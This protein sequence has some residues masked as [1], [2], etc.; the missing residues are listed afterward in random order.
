[1]CRS[2]LLNPCTTNGIRQHHSHT[3]FLHLALSCSICDQRYQNDDLLSA[4]YHHN[5][6]QLVCTTGI[7]FAACAA[8]PLK[9]CD[10]ATC[11]TPPWASLAHVSR[12]ATETQSHTTTAWIAQRLADSKSYKPKAKWGIR[13]ALRTIPKRRAAVFLQLASGHA[14]IGTHLA[15]I[16]K[17]EADTCWWCDSGR[18]QTRGH[19]FGGC[20]AWK[21]EV[22]TLRKEVERITGRKRRLGNRLKVVTLFHDERLTETILDYLAA[23]E[24]GRRYV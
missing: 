5:L 23:T 21:R 7:L 24:V 10:A 15:R 9:R 3:L 19:L 2:S 13:K 14:L 4:Q 16:K 8:S 17:R 6:K 22:L 1:M 11:H 20:R 12:L 18:K